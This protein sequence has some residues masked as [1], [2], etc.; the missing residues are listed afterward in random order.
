MRKI[1][2]CLPM[3]IEDTLELFDKVVA[4]CNQSEFHCRKYQ[5]FMRG[6]LEVSQLNISLSEMG[7]EEDITD[8]M[9]YESSL[10]YNNL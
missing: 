5:E 7:L 10:E 2:E 3:V 1:D 8:L 4:L 6:Y 9:G